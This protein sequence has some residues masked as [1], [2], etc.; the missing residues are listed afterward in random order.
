MLK[1]QVGN[2][3]SVLGIVRFDEEIIFNGEWYL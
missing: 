2:N 3:P 1:F